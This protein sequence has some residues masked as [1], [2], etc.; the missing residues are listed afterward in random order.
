MPTLGRLFISIHALRKESDGLPVIDTAH[1]IRFQST[2]SVRRATNGKRFGSDFIQFQSTLSVRRATRVR[3]FRAYGSDIS[4][5]AL[6]KESDLGFHV[7]VF[8][9][10]AF[11]STLSVRRATLYTPEYTLWLEFQSTLSVRR[12][13]H[14]AAH[15]GVADL[16]SIHALR[17]ESDAATRSSASNHPNFNPRSP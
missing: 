6:R 4:I 2:L 1:N 12:A 11:Q 3:R 10:F 17:K 13:T 9:Q 16:I 7:V 14:G 8:P 5:H 15:D